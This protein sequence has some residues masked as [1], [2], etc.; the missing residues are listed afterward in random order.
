MW[1]GLAMVAGGYGAGSARLH[2]EAGSTAP[3]A[4]LG[5]YTRVM[6]HNASS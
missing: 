3:G 4:G 6:I 2:A 5:D 1:G